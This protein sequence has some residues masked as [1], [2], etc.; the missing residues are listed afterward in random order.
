M[1]ELPSTSRCHNVYHVNL[2]EPYHQSSNESNLN[3][4]PIPWDESI[5]ELT[6]IITHEIKDDLRTYLLKYNDSTEEWQD[7]EYCQD[8]HWEE[9]LAYIINHCCTTSCQECTITCK[10]S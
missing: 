8:A 10:I 1:L 3:K 9:L 7:L 4:Q 5:K 2:L 6:D